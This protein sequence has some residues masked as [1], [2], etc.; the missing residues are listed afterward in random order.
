MIFKFSATTFLVVGLW[1]EKRYKICYFND[2]KDKPRGIVR[3]TFQPW[4]VFRNI[5]SK[6]NIKSLKDMISGYKLYLQ[7]CLKNFKYILIKKIDNS[8][9]YNHNSSTNLLIISGL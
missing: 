4:Y 7:S 9:K 2:A 3:L 1:Y 5:L 6:M 8:V